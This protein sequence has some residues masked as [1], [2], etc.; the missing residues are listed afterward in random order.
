M[1]I[2]LKRSLYFNFFEKNQNGR[3]EKCYSSNCKN[4]CLKIFFN[5]LRDITTTPRIGLVPPLKK[6]EIRLFKTVE[7]S[8]T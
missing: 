8:E 3:N 4:F 2:F 7:I 5:T 1:Y 6:D